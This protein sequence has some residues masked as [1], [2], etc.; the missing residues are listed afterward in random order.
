MV[1]K[2]YYCSHNVVETLPTRASINEIQNPSKYPESINDHL[3]GRH[4][5]VAKFCRRMLYAAIPP[6]FPNVAECYSIPTDMLC[7]YIV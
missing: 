1:L 3:I 5:I 2:N 6:E 7:V 4:R